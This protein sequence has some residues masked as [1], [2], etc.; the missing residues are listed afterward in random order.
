MP[1]VFASL[2]HGL[3]FFCIV[4]Q[5]TTA[6]CLINILLHI[7]QTLRLRLSNLI[8]YFD[9]LSDKGYPLRN[10]L[11]PP[12]SFIGGK[13]YPTLVGYCLFKNKLP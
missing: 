7:C 5:T 4:S 2:V 1:A 3:S 9:R 8:F 10:H 11:T 6:F 12:S 13:Q